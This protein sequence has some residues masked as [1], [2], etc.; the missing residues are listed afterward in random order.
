MGF[1]LQIKKFTTLN[2]WWLLLL[3]FLTIIGLYIVAIFF[4]III[5]LVYWYTKRGKKQRPSNISTL[6]SETKNAII[7]N[8]LKRIKFKKYTDIIDIMNYWT[9]QYLPTLDS[10][11]G[12]ENSELY[13]LSKFFVKNKENISEIEKKING[14]L[15][16]YNDTRSLIDLAI[17]CTNTNPCH[18]DISLLLLFLL[19]FRILGRDFKIANRQKDIYKNFYDLYRTIVGDPSIFG[20][21]YYSSFNIFSYHDFLRLHGINIRGLEQAQIN[22]PGKMPKTTMENVN[23]SLFN[24]NPIDHFPYSSVDINIYYNIINEG[25]VIFN[26]NKRFE[27][28]V[29]FI[30]NKRVKD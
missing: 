3:A 10:F 20:G 30:I 6:E 23:T 1:F 25:G 21:I 9:L 11:K 28:M 26:M 17:K 27:E 19:I 18:D 13:K 12:C 22:E 24:I 16:K 2:K 29:E 14:V 15:L 5:V 4:L 7:K 8:K